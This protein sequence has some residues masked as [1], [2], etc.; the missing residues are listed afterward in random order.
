MNFS[1]SINWRGLATIGLA[2]IGVWVTLVI[3]PGG[4][5]S[6]MVTLGPAGRQPLL[7][8]VGVALTLAVVPVTRFYLG[9]LLKGVDRL[10]ARAPAASSVM[11]GVMV[12]GYLL[13]TVLGLHRPLYPYIHDESS[14][15]IQAHQ[16]AVG[17]LWFPAHPLGDFFDS[18]QLFVKPVY[19]SAYFPGT[20]L[21][22]VPGI[23]L[24]VPAWLWSILIAGTV[25]GLLFRIVVE[26]LDGA[27]AIVAVL[28]M[29][30]DDGFRQQATLTVGQPPLL[31]Y[32]L[33]AVWTW[34]CW[35]S[36]Q[37]RW[38]LLLIGLSL[39]LAAVTRPVDALCFAIPIGIAVV[40]RS[41][42]GALKPVALLIAGAMPMLM[43]Q[44]AIDKGVTGE[45]F[46]TPFRVYA[47]QDYPGTAY[48]FHPF[49]AAARPASSLPQKQAL[50]TNDYRLLVQRHRWSN[51][52]TDL[53]V[54]QGG[55]APSRVLLTLTQNSPFVF[56]LLIPLML[57]CP[58]AMTKG[59][60]LVIASGILFLGLYIPYAFFFPGYVTSAGPAVILAILTG[61]RAAETAF[62]PASRAIRVGL[63]VWV[64]GIG[65]ASLPQWDPELKDAIFENPMLATAEA[66]IAKLHDPAIIF[67]RYDPGRDTNAEPVY[68]ADVAWPDDARVI[69][70]HDLGRR[71]DEVL[72]Y[73]REKSPVRK[74][75]VFDEKTAQLT[76]ITEVG[77]N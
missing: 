51:V 30:A 12:V 7:V 73:Y 46:R 55:L 35:R 72:Q 31:M 62:A 11:A 69:R 59:R 60:M 38:Q 15:L 52:W 63:M 64:V 26:L 8:M 10:V 29:M 9:G 25:C 68:N 70:L 2:V 18:F 66:D 53:F 58:A 36:S 27:S 23:W 57:L 75:Y 74:V 71:N 32:A 61:I 28:L 44:L 42:S 54:R 1:S 22:H 49:D 13:L 76:A 14:Y 6:A 24:H 33:T 21:A 16:L 47:D 34:L 77:R 48:G 65:I 17:R 39:G 19:A 5:N 4:W 40:V 43:M 3:I 41:G 37:R 50:Y 56:P 20:A 45:W 67:F